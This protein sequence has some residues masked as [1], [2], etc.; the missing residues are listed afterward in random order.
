MLAS[1][2]SIHE[3][4]FQSVIIKVLHLF[5]L[6]TLMSGVLVESLLSLDI[7]GLLHL[8]IAIVVL[9]GCI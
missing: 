3:L 7:S 9:H 5:I 2:Q 1:L 6:F 4:I 8:L